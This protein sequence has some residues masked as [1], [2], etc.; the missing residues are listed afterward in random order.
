MSFKKSFAF[1]F[2]VTLAAMALDMMYHMATDV[3]VH[4]PYVLVKT[5]V[6]GFTLTLASYWIGINWKDG[7]VWSFLSSALFNIYY[8]FAEPTLDRT[9]FTLDEAAIFI[10]IHFFCIIIPYLLVYKYLIVLP[11]P[12]RKLSENTMYGI[13]S[14]GALVGALGL[15]IPKAILKAN[16]LLFGLSYNDHVLVGTLAGLAA[17]VAGY[18]LILKK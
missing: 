18:K 8:V 11:V 5:T 15:F 12:G 17:L 13:I 3:A 14:I 1:A 7:V 10:V 4:L 2:V 16:G 9:V 6:V